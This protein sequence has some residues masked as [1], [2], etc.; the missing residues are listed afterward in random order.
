M[1]IWSLGPLVKAV[2]TEPAAQPG[3]LWKALACT[4]FQDQTLPE[5]N[6]GPIFAIS[7]VLNAN[8]GMVLGTRDLK[9]RVLGPSG[10]GIT[11][12][13]AGLHRVG[14]DKETY[15]GSA[16]DERICPVCLNNGTCATGAQPLASSVICSQKD[17]FF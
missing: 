14:T 2:V 3:D 8:K 11:F 9:Y 16:C 1:F 6:T 13:F 10:I 7:P 15:H 4:G 5:V 12:S 17:L